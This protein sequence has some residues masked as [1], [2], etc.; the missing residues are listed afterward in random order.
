MRLFNDSGAGHTG[1]VSGADDVIRHPV[2]PGLS[3]AGVGELTVCTVRVGWWDVDVC[4]AL[5]FQEAIMQIEGVVR[6]DIVCLVTV[7]SFAVA[8]WEAYPYP[9]RCIE[10]WLFVVGPAVSAPSRCG[11]V[12]TFAIGQ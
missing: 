5:L 1:A 8:C 12:P 4:V 7:R 9:S 6:F 11:R 10:W 3:H 2:F